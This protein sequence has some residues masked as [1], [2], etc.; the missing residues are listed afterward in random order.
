MAAGVWSGQWVQ[1]RAWGPSR[2]QQQQQCPWGWLPAEGVGG[3]EDSEPG[4]RKK[5]KEQI[6]YLHLF[7]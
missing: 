5:K 4:E 3:E 6:T 2:R 1:L 7:Q